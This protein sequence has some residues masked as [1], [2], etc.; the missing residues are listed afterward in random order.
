MG[1]SF[2]IGLK[3]LSSFILTNQE[4]GTRPKK[5]LNHENR[6]GEFETNRV[7]IGVIF[8]RILQQPKQMRN[9]LHTFGALTRV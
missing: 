4:A 8:T 2:P 1:E 7:I 5:G 9:S 6:L 3:V